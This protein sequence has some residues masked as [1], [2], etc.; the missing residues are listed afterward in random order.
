VNQEVIIQPNHGYIVG[1]NSLAIGSTINT[2]NRNNA[3]YILDGIYINGPLEGKA[4]IVPF[5]SGPITFEN[6]YLDYYDNPFNPPPFP[7][8]FFS[9]TIGAFDV[10]GVCDI[11]FIPAP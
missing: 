6:Y 1:F 11:G 9:N 2:L 4:P 8:T 5:T 10:P 3:I 7:G